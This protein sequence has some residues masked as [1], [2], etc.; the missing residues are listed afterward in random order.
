MLACSLLAGL[1]LRKG[2]V[3]A[4][5]IT[6]GLC[7]GSLGLWNMART[8]PEHIPGHYIH[9]AKGTPE[10]LRIQILEEHRHNSRAFRYLGEVTSV[11][12]EPAS[13]KILLE[14]EATAAEPPLH[15]GYE[16]FTSGN[17]EGIPPP[18]NP[19]QFDYN[20]YLKGMGIE[21]RLRI[22]SGA[23]IVSKKASSGVFG[24]INT[25]RQGLLRS[26]GETGLAVKELGIAKALL[27][28]DRS[29]IDT[30]VHKGYRKAGALHLLAVSGLHVGILAAFLSMMLMPLKRSRHG[31]VPH[32][33]LMVLLLW[34]YAVLAGF[35]ASTVRAV[36]LFSLLAYAQYRERPGETLHL[37]FLSWMAMLV[38]I[39]PYWL[40]QVGFQLSFAAVAA[41][42]AFYPTL[43]NLWPWKQ[44]P[45]RYP[46]KLL[47]VSLAAQL[48]T[49]P[50][51]LYYFH[52]F[53]GLFL[54]TNLVLVPG[55]GLV[56]ITGFLALFLQT[57][58]LLP[59]V[60]LN[61][62]QLLLKLMNGFVHWVGS[63]ERFHLDGIPWS[64]V[65][66]VLGS[67]AI[68]L[69]GAYLKSQKKS[70]I[71]AVL[72]VLAAMQVW[73]LAGMLKAAGGT[74]LLIP[75]KVGSSGIWT[76]KGRHLQVL[77]RDSTEFAPQVRDARKLWGFNG[78]TYDNLANHY[79]IGPCRLRVIDSSGIYSPSEP[80]PDYLLLTGSPRVH[81]DRLL[82]RL[83][84][85]MV[86]A[87]GS[88][89]HS[90]LTHW[91]KSCRSHGTPFYATAY[92]GAFITPISRPSRSIHTGRPSI[93]CD[94]A[95]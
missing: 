17:P 61:G 62:Y 95:P 79:R 92:Q 73:A 89:Y 25:L 42:V 8:L 12:N 74:R 66:L 76:L 10:K 57:F 20:S 14:I 27:L 87:D 50:L 48:G 1:F 75:H 46:G 84:P 4:F 37:L 81:L 53:P 2:A 86:I 52:Q 91:E 54:L 67:A 68:I 26:L 72:F 90:L 28:G 9:K 45:W 3:G 23:F 16:V 19:G 41:I 5:W 22:P 56:L 70:L 58:S 65:E 88:N 78:V 36:I 71:T 49:L 32:L 64:M 93:K 11:G 35:K 82:E 30:E 18:L 15:A 47:C 94:R 40:L 31:K 59:P 69:A 38:L 6:A 85:G 21:R 39:D 44:S 60:M 33:I 13:G 80:R 7:F 51:T 77:S 83:S 43:Y 63:H 24:K 29:Q 55:I 34:C